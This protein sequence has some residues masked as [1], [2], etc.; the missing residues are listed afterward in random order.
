MS[1]KTFWR[2]SR[3]RRDERGA[4]AVVVA[5]SFA[6]VA[7]GCAFG[8]DIAN[9]SMQRQ[10][11]QNTIDA[12]AQAGTTYLP[13]NAA[14]AQRTAIEFAQENIPDLKPTV[15]P[16]CIVGSTKGQVTLGHIPATCN[17]TG[18]PAQATYS[19]MRCDDKI[20]AIPCNPRVGTCNS[21]HVTGERIVRHWFAPIIGINQSSTGAVSSTSCRGSCGTL[22]PNAMD[23]AFVADRTPSMKEAD[24]RKMQSAIGSSLTTMT[25][26]L[27]FVTLGTI[28]KSTGVGP[29]LTDVA[30]D[31]SPR[32]GTWMPLGFS[33]AYL[34]GK[35]G[36][37]HRALNSADQIG[38]NLTC[39]GQTN[40]GRRPNWGTHLAAPM[41]SASRMLLGLDRSNLAALDA[42]RKPQ[43]PDGTKIS[44]A[45]ILE[46]DGTPEETIAVPRYDRNT[47]RGSTSL[48]VAGDVAAGNL[49]NEPRG[50]QNLLRVAQQAKDRGI[51]V[52][53]VAFGDARTNGCLKDF[54]NGRFSGRPVRDVLAEV[55]SPRAPGIPSTA[56]SC[57]SPAAI[58]AENTDGDFFFCAADGDQLKSIFATA[59][60]QISGNTRFIRLPAA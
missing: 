6:V 24:F 2:T 35:L 51:L 29:C 17:P 30:V 34:T 37:E 38:H 53:T 41:K 59:I 1:I 19:G 42:K 8:L 45:I 31:G 33:D 23:V 27:Q 50:C 18:G 57:S 20:C 40:R 21:L 39:M 60:A 55:A 7:A 46:T 22:L 10:E 54:S 56:N 52:I 48:D 13:G 9:L 26:E 43:L 47:N 58:Q 32:D 11:L 15:E 49:S 25:P 44:K 28:H 36:D 16:L 14:T 3:Q 5:A 4:S 12:A